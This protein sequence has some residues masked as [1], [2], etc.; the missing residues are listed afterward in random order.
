[1]NWLDNLTTY[2]QKSL[3]DR[4]REVLWGRGVSDEQIETYRLGYLEDGLPNLDLCPD[5]FRAW[6]DDGRKLKDVFLLP[7]TNTQNQVL[8]VQFRYVDRSRKGYMDFL[9]DDEEVSL[10]GLGPAMPHIWRTKSVW[11]VEGGFDLFPI[12]RV[13]PQTVAT[14]TAKVSEPL[15]RILR[16]F[17]D[18]VW[19]G[20]DNDAAGIRGA[21]SFI[22]EYGDQVRVHEV[23]FPRVR[24]VNGEQSKDPA[25]VWEAWGDEQLGVFIR[26]QL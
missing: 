19:L 13:H 15:F 20:Y 17:V 7:M 3:G 16:R 11:L 4:E 23:R 10:F 24:K 25:D 6:S 22:K 2:A 12:Q 26:Q 1:M 18:D 9:A 14:M 5:T 21:Q 8:G